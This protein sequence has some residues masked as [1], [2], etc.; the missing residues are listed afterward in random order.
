MP[1][2]RI[3]REIEDI[4]NRLDHFVPEERMTSRVRRRSSGA[5]AAFGRALLAPLAGISLRQVMLTAL[6]LVLAGF[7][8]MRIHPVYGR[9]LLIGGLILFLTTFALS[10][11]Q[12][13]APPGPATEQR[14]RG[15]PIE[16]RPATLAER[17]R[18][19]LQGKRRRRP[20]R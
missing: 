13:G 4:L 3:Q 9:W 18:G 14:W 6:I 19:W 20:S 10:F 7:I 17:L 15:R 1:E 5:A 12:R 16:L 11:L 8:G 2:D